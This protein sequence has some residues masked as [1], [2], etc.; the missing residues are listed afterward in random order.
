M[1][2]FALYSALGHAHTHKN[3]CH[4]Y[5]KPASYPSQTKDIQMAGRNLEAAKLW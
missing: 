5:Q 2:H 3:K 4:A 1:T